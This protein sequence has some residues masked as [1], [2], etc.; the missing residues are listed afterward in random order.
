MPVG[1]RRFA[2]GVLLALTVATS[3]VAEPGRRLW[4]FVTGGALTTNP[5][6]V[7][8]AT[9]ALLAEDRY[10]YRIGF[11]G[12]Y[13]DRFALADIP[14]S[15]LGFDERGGFLVGVRGGAVQHVDPVEGRVSTLFADREVYGRTEAVLAPIV[16]DDGTILLF[17][18]DGTIRAYTYRLVPL[19]T[20]RLPEPID[21]QPIIYDE[22]TIA[23]ATRAGSLVFLTNDG[24]VL[25]VH[26]LDATPTSISV[27]RTATGNFEDSVEET[28]AARPEVVIGTQEGVVFLVSFDGEARRMVGASGA[29]RRVAS[30][31][32]DLR[33]TVEGDQISGGVY[34]ALDERG[35]LRYH[36][37]HTG[38]AW[39]ADLGAVSFVDIE[40]SLG[41]QGPVII[42]AADD[43]RLLAL[44][45][46]GQ[47]TWV[48]ETGE[49]GGVRRLSTIDES[50]IVSAGNSWIVYGHE[51]A[52]PPGWTRS[53][54][55]AGSTTRVLGSLPY[56]EDFSEYMDYVV[57]NEGLFHSDWARRRSAMDEVGARVA[58]GRLRVSYPYIE[59]LLM[60]V[61][62]EPFDSPLI[63]GS[64]VTNNHPELRAQA[65]RLLV[66]LAHRF[67]AEPLLEV[68]VA[69][70]DPS[71]LR[72]YLETLPDLPDP[73]RSIR[74][75][76]LSVAQ[77][78]IVPS[79]DETLAVALVDAI[80]RV[81]R[82]GD[83]PLSIE[84]YDALNAVYLADFP[85]EV[86]DHAI[87]VLR[88]LAGRSP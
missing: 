71:V 35:L 64:R 57:L 74:R 81:E 30:L 4:R 80:E 67:T 47:A 1:P 66:Q 37:A 13:I 78:T 68:F 63:H 65:V 16:R 48:A 61:V 84:S 27:E 39:S 87:S 6:V 22:G 3:A 77:E 70:R 36:D 44:N 85:R 29:V 10:L 49:R 24:E 7:G 2:V 18:R 50:L 5:I 12:A 28:S 55:T 73:Q 76:M 52:P 40:L 79:L 60:R 62:R 56:A 46:S 83:A 42:V 43:G 20:Y 19:W 41:P 45:D 86:R 31:S 75:A 34:A 21:V 54:S 8:P 69:E 15:P 11:D 33:R 53:M 88:A 32:A 17:S 58:E 9:I 26:R 72:A 23:I 59:D 82:N 14:T 25:G 38:E 51:L